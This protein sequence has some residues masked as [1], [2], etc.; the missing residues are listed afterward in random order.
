M[1]RGSRLINFMAAGMLLLLV[2]C[3]K[4]LYFSE[5]RNFKHNVW[6]AKD[7]QKFEVEITDTSVLY[8]IIFFLR[9]DTDYDY[10]NAW[11]YLHSTLPDK[12]EYKEAHQFFISNENGEWLGK[13]SGS[14]VESEMIFSGRKF[15]QA[16]KYKFVI[17]QATTQKRLS[18]IS[19]VGLKIIKSKKS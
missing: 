1:I 12:K 14:L 15:P 2:S 10:N 18:H 16:G 5:V 4:G 6:E 3:E 13:K 11:I 17:E 9:V 7:Q 19:D 8:D